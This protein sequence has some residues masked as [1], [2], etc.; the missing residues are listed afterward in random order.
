MDPHFWLLLLAQC[1]WVDS[2]DPPSDL[3]FPTNVMMHEELDLPVVGALVPSHL[4]DIQGATWG[5]DHCQDQ[6]CAGNA[7]CQTA[8]ATCC[9]Q[10]QGHHLDSYQLMQ[11]SCQKDSGTGW[12]FGG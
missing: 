5:V 11:T 6:T 9:F 8:I 1:D 4:D 2:A 10:S 3:L 12:L 7:H